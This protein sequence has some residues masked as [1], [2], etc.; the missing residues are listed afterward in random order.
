MICCCQSRAV[1]SSGEAWL[2][3]G[4][5]SG[6][7]HAAMPGSRSRKY[8][9]VRI[10][11]ASQK[12]PGA[13][14][15][16]EGTSLKPVQRAPLRNQP[17]MRG[18]TMGSASVVLLYGTT[19]KTRLSRGRLSTQT[20]EPLWACAG[21]R[22]KRSSL[23]ATLCSGWQALTRTWKPA[24][25]APFRAAACHKAARICPRSGLPMNSIETAPNSGMPRRQINGFLGGGMGCGGSCGGRGGGRKIHEQLPEAREV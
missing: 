15:E 4:G 25:A 22:V 19:I 24:K 21:T 14:K 2:P 10:S 23:K 3:I 8:P 17:L 20:Q 16:P 12:K 9:T 5:G 7:M 1:V 13:T 18:S 11:G 6:V